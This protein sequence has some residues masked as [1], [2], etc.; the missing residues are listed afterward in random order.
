MDSVKEESEDISLMEGMEMKSEDLEREELEEGNE[1][2]DELKE[3]ET[4]R[5]ECGAE[6]SQENTDPPQQ[7]YNLRRKTTE[8]SLTCSQWDMGFTSE[9]SLKFHMGKHKGKKPLTSTP[10]TSEKSPPPTPARDKTHRLRTARQVLDFLWN[11]DEMESEGEQCEVPEGN[12]E[13]DGTFEIES[14]SGAES[15]SETE[16]AGD[17]FQEA[18][19]GTV[20]VEQPAGKPQDKPQE[21][22]N[23]G[24]PPGPTSYAKDNIRSPLS[25]LLCLIDPEMWENLY[26]YTEAEIK[27][28][29]AKFT[30]TDDELKAFFGLIYLRGVTGGKHRKLDEYWS[31]DLGMPIFR[32]TIS[33]QKFREIMRHMRF[34][35]KNTRATRLMT[36]KFAM[37]SEIFNKFVQNCIASYTPGQ[38]ITVDEQLFPTKTRCRFTQYMPN[39][40]DKFGIKF[41]VAADS[42]TNYMLNTFPYLGKDEKKQAG[43]LLTENIVMRLME[44]FLGKGRNV[45]TGSFFTTLSLANSLLE[46][47][48][49]IVGAIKRNKREMPR[50]TEVQSELFSTKILKAGKVTLTI[51]QAK[52]KKNI[53]ILSTMHQTVSTDNS[54]KK[55]PDTVYY[56]NST[57]GGVDAMDQMARLYSVKGGTRR[58]PIAVFYNI[59]DLAAINAHILYK[60]CMNVNIS[61][62][63]FILELVKELCARQRIAN[64]AARRRLLPE[65][66][67]SPIKRKQCQVGRCSGNKTFDICETCKRF[68]CGKCSK[69]SAKLCCECE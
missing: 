6:E 48:T 28:S 64:V 62:K 31:S 61:R 34:D 35:D 15:D 66:P 41:W 1:L 22:N 20:W 17:S 36:D 23:P 8:E 18:K 16:H 44:P 33:R 68:V 59:L 5:G 49:T 54:T 10:L 52:P 12:D 26:K 3:E 51:Y 32:E 42:V 37:I 7:K 29:N 4:V 9:K 55:L 2:Q 25:S 47:R 69:I 19:N 14:D 45:T 30:L 11:I 56:Y 58:W 24:E 46:H 65:S 40:P 60:Q 50:C 53:C 43:Q 57:K 21:W 67:F 63:T 13:A 27:R 39:K 38:N